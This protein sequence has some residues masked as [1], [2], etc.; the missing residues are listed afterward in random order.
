MFIAVWSPEGCEPGRV[1]TPVDSPVNYVRRRLRPSSL[2][3]SSP[4]PL[5]LV[6]CPCALWCC[7]LCVLLGVCPCFLFLLLFCFRLCSS[8]FPVSG[9]SQSCVCSC[10]CLVVSEPCFP[11]MLIAL[12][13]PQQVLTSQCP[14]GSLLELLVCRKFIH[15]MVLGSFVARTSVVI[16]SCT[17]AF[18]SCSY[19]RFVPLGGTCRPR[20]LVA[21]ECEEGCLAHCS[22]QVF[23]RG[24]PYPTNFGVELASCGAPCPAGSSYSVPLSGLSVSSSRYGLLLVAPSY[25]LTVSSLEYGMACLLGCLAVHQVIA[26]KCF[27]KLLARGSGHCLYYCSKLCNA[28]INNHGLRHAGEQHSSCLPDSVMVDD[29]DVDD[30]QSP[31]HIGLGVYKPDS[32]CFGPMAGSPTMGEH[33]PRTTAL[34]FKLAGVNCDCFIHEDG[35]SVAMALGHPLVRMSLGGGATRKG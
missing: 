15:A 4:S 5:C 26:R 16:G 22:L 20:C 35:L 31:R 25:S 21:G 8:V 11:K 29:D 19:G 23:G 32:S 7:R 14:F 13:P 6:S 33:T 17:S 34:I 12:N 10:Q 1:W 28:K 30:F 27:Y 9:P 18:V 24:A 2:A 3:Q